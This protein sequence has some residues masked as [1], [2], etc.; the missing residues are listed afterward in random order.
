MIQTTSL[1]TNESVRGRG[2]I[3]STITEDPI[4]TIDISMAHTLLVCLFYI[5]LLV[6]I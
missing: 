1:L 2:S 4:Q 3:S 5:L 6:L